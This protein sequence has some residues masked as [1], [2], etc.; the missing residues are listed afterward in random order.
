MAD[1]IFGVMSN[2]NVPLATSNTM[3]MRLKEIY[4]AELAARGLHVPNGFAFAG[5]S[6]R[7]GGITAIREAA[8]RNGISDDQL[9]YLLMKYRR[10]RHPSSLEVY[11]SENRDALT[12]L[13]ARIVSSPGIGT[14]GAPVVG[15]VRGTASRSGGCPL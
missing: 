9:R 5:H 12:A 1:V 6:S 11:L 13:T 14:L 15:T 3:I 8:R 2:P 7:R 4:V 10:W